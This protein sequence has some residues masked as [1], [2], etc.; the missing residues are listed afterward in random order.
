MSK[1]PKISI[2]TPS[3]NQAKFL[4]QTILSIINQDYPDLE[5]I[6]IDGGSTDG[7]VEIIRKYEEYLT[8]WV[9]E[10][11]NGQ[12]N[13]INKGFAMCTGDVLNWINSDDR[14][15]PG[16]LKSVAEIVRAHPD[17]GAWVGSCKL[18]DEKGV[19][20]R[21]NKPRGLTRDKMAGWGN[22]GHFFQ[23]SCFIARK[24]W[25]KYGPLDES[26]YCCF[27]LDLYLKIAKDYKFHGVNKVWSEA[28]IHREA[29]TSARIPLLRAERHIVQARHGYESLAIKNIERAE[30]IAMK[31]EKV[32]KL[33][34]LGKR[35]LRKILNGVR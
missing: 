26:L 13:A 12:A 15:K 25:D 7:S 22:T 24:A 23:P 3:F 32:L 17:A 1:I 4:E 21:T 35:G 34:K 18:V 29:K 9:S 28:T 30:M 31:V 11:D 5:Y 16:A 2:V 6:I 27:D 19:L 20:L 33:L 10:K 14:L 8:Y